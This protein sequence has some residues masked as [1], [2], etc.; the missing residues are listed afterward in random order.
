MGTKY[1]DKIKAYQAS[2]GPEAPGEWAPF[3]YQDLAPKGWFGKFAQR[4]LERAIPAWLFFSRETMPCARALGFY[5][6]TRDEDVQRALQDHE[7]F[8]V[9]Y[10]MEMRELSR[11][12]DGLEGDFVLGLD[13]PA[14]QRQ[15]RI[16]RRIMHP[17]DLKRC[18]EW[19]A[20]FASSLLEGGGGRLDVVSDF[21]I[22]I[23][24]EICRRYFGLSIPD[25]DAF[26]QWAIAVSAVLFADPTGDPTKRRL[27][28]AGAQRLCSV[29]DAAIDR[30]RRGPDSERPRQVAERTIVE[31]LVDLSMEPELELSPPEIRAIVL[32][33]VVGFIPTNGL[34]AAKMIEELLRQP[35]ALE[36]AKLQARSGN[37]EELRRILLEAGRLNPAL[38]PGQWRYTTRDV[39]V[40]SGRRKRTVPKGATVMVS[41]MS[42]MRDRRAHRQPGTFNSDRN[43]VPELLFGHATH[44]CL[45]QHLA[46]EIITAMC[47]VLFRQQNLRRARGRLGSMQRV[48]YF[49]SRLDMEYESATSEQ[50]MVLCSIPVE[51]Q[52]ERDALE[53]ILDELGNPARK[54]VAAAL[55]ATG[56]VHFASCSVVD[57]GDGDRRGPFYLLIELNVDGSREAALE[58]VAKH[59]GSWLL[60]VIQAARPGDARPLV[61]IL[62]RHCL[63]LQFRPW[64]A[65]GLN[66]VGMGDFPISDIEKQARLREAVETKLTAILKKH[67]EASPG[68]LSRPIAAL[69][70][71][72]REIRGGSAGADLDA[73]LVQPS[74]KRTRFSGWRKPESFWAPLKNVMQGGL[75]RSGAQLL[76]SSWLL[77]II[78]AH[79][80]LRGGNDRWGEWGT[81]VWLTHIGTIGAL[82]LLMTVMFWAALAAAAYLSFRWV[83]AREKPDDRVPDADR[84]KEL[85]AREN[86][87]GYLQNHITAVTVLKKGLVRRLALSFS[88]WGIRQSLHWFRPG[89]VVTMGTIHYAK[90]FR[91]PGT[92]KLIFQ[93]NFDGSWESYLEDFVTRAHPGQTAAWSNGEG[94]PKSKGLIGEGAKDADRF[95]RWV[96]RQQIPTRFWYS[97]FPQL[98]TKQIR[99]NAL[100][101]D[102]L[103]RARTDTDARA[104]LDLLGSAPRQRHE[105]ES[106][107]IQSLVFRGLK[108][109]LYTAYI[110]F[111]LPDDPNARGNWL[112]ELKRDISFGKFPADDEALY[113]AL[114]AMGLAKYGQGAGAGADILSEFPTAFRAGMAARPEILGDRSHKDPDARWR[115]SDGDK[116]DEAA[117]DGVLILYARSKEKLEEGI[118]HQLSSLANAGGALVHTVIRTVPIDQNGDVDE[119]ATGTFSYEHFGFRDGISTP[120]IRGTEQFT[121]RSAE[122][123]VVDP[124]EFVLG[125]PNNQGYF[126]PSITVP[127]ATDTAENLAVTSDAMTFGIAHFPDADEQFARRDLGRNGTFL[128]FRQLDQDVRGFRNFVSEQAALL[129]REYG[130]APLREATGADVTPTWVAAKMM[131]RWPDGRTLV[132]NPTDRKRYGD[133]HP[134]NDF[135]YGRDDPRGH[136]CPLGAHVRRANPRDSLEPGDPLE[137]AITRRHLMIRRGRTY[138]Y[139][140]ANKVYPTYKTESFETGLVF[141][142]ICAD[143]ERQFEL[144]QQTWLGFPSFH[145]LT[146]EP[147]PI[148]TQ[149]VSDQVRRFTIPTPSG[150]LI[151]GGMQSF[152]SMRGGGYF[153]LPS[154]AA[155]QYLI[156]F[157]VRESVEH[158]WRANPQRES[159]STPGQGPIGHAE[160]A[161]G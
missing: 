68:L 45:G 118:Q 105:L 27:A 153:F 36:S 108:R 161:N 28:L 38:A 134:D 31:R 30:A 102:G 15:N 141:V 123:D 63:D 139:D 2:N 140:Q 88:L 120:V 16:I 101:H 20:A 149:A 79:V 14:Q 56:I 107:E 43:G 156:D 1:F 6:I 47:L 151:V 74:R 65:T 25:P 37:A 12:E 152:V 26:A 62:R 72:R 29:I 75:A 129:N 119:H 3:N 114:S 35:K 116:D 146:A 21:A 86:K 48:G 97:R 144:V 135:A 32:G 8:A 87:P 13:G 122:R 44:K 33:L 130:A 76:L 142:A 92:R 81:G 155:I 49:P 113:I 55:D 67:D 128:V 22:R 59:A 117:A 121:P 106:T 41:T 71:V 158:L 145:G 53:R 52:V 58:T 85:A 40:G 7:S 115:W 64:G 104:W 23:P 132:G 9:P 78:V 61:E 103:A 90:W 125:Y 4:L 11:G 131:G 109:A 34:A 5:W 54:D 91:L 39:A 99:T 70:A 96:R 95:K 18:R 17:D 80:A 83:E 98:T 24:T 137:Q 148:T 73:F 133:E 138:F 112:R 143:L 60:P 100:V 82:S 66:F 160:N 19:S 157:G 159:A 136:G 42:A 46:V 51:A 127:A 77:F 147:D 126:A 124:G 110:P 10:G 50:T 69:T 154:R 93:S 89:F 94:F 84:L 57:S 111:K 150:P